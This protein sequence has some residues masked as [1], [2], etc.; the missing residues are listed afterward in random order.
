VAEADCGQDGEDGFCGKS[1][2]G[3]CL[4]GAHG[5]NYQ[6]NRWVWAWIIVML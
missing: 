1:F 2:W 5:R 4:R 3:F 6:D